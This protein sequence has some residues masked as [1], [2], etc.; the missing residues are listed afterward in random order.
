MTKI[1]DYERE[2]LAQE[3]ERQDYEQNA[4]IERMLKKLKEIAVI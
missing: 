1:R 4:T 3:M 2:R